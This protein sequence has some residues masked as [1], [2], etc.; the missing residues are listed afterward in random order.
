[1]I[2]VWFLQW[3][4]CFIL[5]KSNLSSSLRHSW[6]TLPYIFFLVLCPPATLPQTH[7]HCTVLACKYAPQN[8][9][10]GYI[11]DQNTYILLVVCCINVYTYIQY[12]WVEWSL[13]PYPGITFNK[14]WL[15]RYPFG[16]HF[17][18]PEATDFW[19]LCFLQV[20]L[21]NWPT[22]WLLSPHR[23]HRW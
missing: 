20:F 12:S 14:R 7:V 6:D 23:C 8:G 1:M 22:R 16:S 3:L 15:A 17:G 2:F 21:R 10:V 19:S 18:Y 13:L 5:P 9:Y 11:S 4:I